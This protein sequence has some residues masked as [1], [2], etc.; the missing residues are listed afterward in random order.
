MNELINL[1]Q[2]QNIDLEINATKSLNKEINILNGIEKSLEIRNITTYLIKAI[3]DD[4][5]VLIKTENL[6]HPESILENIEN[7]LQVQ[8]NAN[9]NKL[10]DGHIKNE[11][12]NRNK[13]DFKQIKKDLL[14]LEDLKKQY[15][16]KSIDVSYDY[17]EDIVEINNLNAELK[18]ECLFHQ[19]AIAIAFEKN[20][21]TKVLETYYYA[22]EYNFLDFKNY[23]LPKL[24]DLVLKL[25][26]TSLNTN[27]YKVILNNEVVADL[28]TTFAGMFSAKGIYLKE[29]LLT[30]KLNTKVFSDKITIIEDPI[31][32]EYTI[33]NYFDSE[34]TKTS[35][36]ELIKDGVFLKAMNNLEY[37]LKLK[38][39][40]T[41][42]AGG[43][44]NL[45]LKPG[46]TTYNDLIKNLD[47]GIIIDNVSGLH[48]GINL[49]TGNISLQAEGLK[50]ENGQKTKGLN[51]IILATNIKEIFN[52]VILVGNDLSKNKLNAF[53][54]S[55]LLSDIAIAGEGEENE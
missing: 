19:F 21:Q 34:G 18:N 40:P 2:K 51:M 3:K 47:N 4:H 14:S 42:N 30:D 31:S 43:Y 10:C 24:E 15:P 36:K 55:L 44:T 1:A 29:S 17:Y 20:N 54:P 35:F 33:K 5:C 13:V 11:I 9:T 16:I 46:K 52:N 12:S 26:S 7:I 53:A 48:C 38:T 45:I 32:D 37:A 28:L 50:V 22:K 23:L 41:G 25:N 27:K 39:E 6:N 8:E 49:K